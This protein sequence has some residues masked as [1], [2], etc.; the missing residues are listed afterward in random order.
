MQFPSH[1][2]LNCS[3]Q[4]HLYQLDLTGTQ[5]CGLVEVDVPRRA[6]VDV[7]RWRSDV[8]QYIWMFVHKH[9]DYLPQFRSLFAQGS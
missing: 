6:H 3:V 4:L 7:S 9:S 8:L 2:Q 5:R 1:C